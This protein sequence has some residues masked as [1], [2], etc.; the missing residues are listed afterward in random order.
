VHL[1]FN[2]LKQ[3]AVLPPSTF[4]KP[5]DWYSGTTA[6]EWIA[7]RA[8]ELTYTSLSLAAFALSVGYDGPPFQWDEERRFLLRC[9]LDS[10]FFHL[11]RIS[12]EDADYIL[13][14]FPIVRRR[15]EKTF[16][17]YRTKRVILEIYDKIEQAKRTGRPYQTRLDPPPGAAHQAND[18]ITAISSQGT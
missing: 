12:H 1:T 16:G 9:E 8:L 15:D 17:E 14:T 10:A 7:S 2:C 11:Y 13:D 18:K 4:T 5:L 6:L 3:L